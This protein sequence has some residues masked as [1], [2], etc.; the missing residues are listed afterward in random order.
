M[1]M[2]GDQAALKIIANRLWPRLRSQAAPISVNVQ[3]EELADQAKAAIDAAL[4]GDITADVLRDL[5]MAM[6]THGRLIELTEL[7]A[8]LRELEERS[9]KPPWEISEPLK[10]ESLREKL[11]LRGKRRRHE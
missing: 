2:E 8:R 7:D 1:A 9:S 5:L 4:S 11:P 6:Y 10:E 3:S